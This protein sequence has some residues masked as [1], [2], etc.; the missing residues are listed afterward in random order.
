MCP[1]RN[2]GVDGGGAGLF[3]IPIMLE[4]DGLS[5]GASMTGGDE[6]ESDMV[7]K[8]CEPGGGRAQADLRSARRPKQHLHVEGYGR[9]KGPQEVAGAVGS[10]EITAHGSKGTS[11]SSSSSSSP[12]SARLAAGTWTAD[13]FGLGYLDPE[14]ARRLRRS[15]AGPP[16]Q[17]D[18]AGGGAGLQLKGSSG[19]SHGG[20]CSTKG[21]RQSEPQHHWQ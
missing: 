4:A 18:L 3:P 5:D 1:V 21:A 12:S 10:H 13:D 20:A 8:K 14:D 16:R 19:A 11:E 17:V 15:G 6:E 2:P 9:R 7:A